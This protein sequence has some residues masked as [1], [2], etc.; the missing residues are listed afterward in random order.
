MTPTRLR[1]A[2]LMRRFSMTEAQAQ[3]LANLIWGAG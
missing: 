3:A 2:Y 1:I